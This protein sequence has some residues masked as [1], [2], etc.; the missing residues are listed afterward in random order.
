MADQKLSSERANLLADVAEMYYLE[1]KTQDEIASIVNVT[2]SMVSRLLT[3]A[4]KKGIIEVRIHR[5]LQ[6]DSFL[7]DSL[8]EQFG[9]LNAKVIHSTGNDRDILLKS[10]GKA[11]AEM[12][13]NY[14]KPHSILGLAWGSTISAVIDEFEV[15]EPLPLKIVQLVG[16]LGTQ[17]KEYDGHGLVLRLAEKLQGQGYYLNAPFICSGKEIAESLMQTPGIRETIEMG[18]ISDVALLGIGST[19]PQYSSFY[20]AGY[21]PLE[22]LNLLIRANAVGDVCGLHFDSFGK[23]ICAD[24][25]ERLVTIRRETLHSIP[26]RIGVAGGVNKEQ[27]ILGA[28]RG[29]YINVLVSDSQTARQML[30][31]A[32]L[33]VG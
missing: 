11:G 5:P 3:E 21:V 27:A 13:H 6:F 20:L 17:N 18:G 15:E 22:E 33:A 30:E 9:L 29:G 28:L 2:R 31:M 10:L 32:R 26:V 7:E 16:A 1:E 25:C 4:R 19:A 12:L 23:E 24:F 14:L 8:K